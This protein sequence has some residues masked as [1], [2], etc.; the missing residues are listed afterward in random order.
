MKEEKRQ[1]GGHWHPALLPVNVWPHHTHTLKCAISE[2]VPQQLWT[3]RTTPLSLALKAHRSMNHQCL[4][5]SNKPGSCN[6]ST[7]VITYMVTHEERRS[8]AEH[9]V[10]KSFLWPNIWSQCYRIPAQLGHQQAGTREPR[11]QRQFAHVLKVTPEHESPAGKVSVPACHEAY[12][13]TV[14]NP[15]LG[16]N[17]R[18]NSHKRRGWYAA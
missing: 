9:R 6:C 13:P 18:K 17:R 7:E 10:P 11:H 12:A 1:L 4:I 5:S 2:K 8:P 16:Q 15:A 3:L 14:N